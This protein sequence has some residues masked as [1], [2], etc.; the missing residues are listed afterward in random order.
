MNQLLLAL[1]IAVFAW[2]IQNKEFTEMT[3]VFPKNI[4]LEDM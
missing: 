3:C 1:T 4:Y 2:V